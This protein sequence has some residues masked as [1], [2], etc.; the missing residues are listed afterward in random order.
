[1]LLQ[2]ADDNPMIDGRNEMGRTNPTKLCLDLIILRPRFLF[3]FLLLFG[4]LPNFFS[5]SS[6][7]F[8]EI[9]FLFFSLSLLVH[10]Q[11]TKSE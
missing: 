8:L 10:E 9:F 5:S 6:L 7:F 2:A 4:Q 11:T 3:L 1:L